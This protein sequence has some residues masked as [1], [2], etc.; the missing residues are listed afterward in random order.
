MNAPSAA[1]PRPIDISGLVTPFQRLTHGLIFGS[2]GRPLYAS[3]LSPCCSTYITCVPPTPAGS[4]SA[5]FCNPRSFRSFTRFTPR[6]TMSSLVP[7][8][9]A[10]VGQVLT[11]AGS[12]PT[13]TRSEHRVHLYA[14]LSFLLMRG[15]LKGQPAMQ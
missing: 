15:M 12:R 5:E 2:L 7:N 4:Y 8:M 6:A 9:S 13:A 3:G 11:H 1:R 10:P 14:L